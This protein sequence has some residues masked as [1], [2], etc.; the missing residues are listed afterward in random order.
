MNA[1]H[2]SLCLALAALLAAC[3]RARPR[4]HDAAV[5]PVDAERVP[6]IAEIPPPGPSADGAE[7]DVPLR[8]IH[9]L[10]EPAP[11]GSTPYAVVGATVPCGF[12]P[13]Y[14]VSERVEGE[15]HLRMRAQR[16]DGGAAG[17]VGGTPVVELV[18]LSQLRL[19]AWRVRDATAHG[20]QDP[21]SPEGPV[22][23][24]VPDDA[25]IAPPA[26]RWTRACDTGADC[27]GGGVCAR[28]GSGSICL[29]PMDPWL[30]LGR[31]C[32]EGTR[33]VEA[34]AVDRGGPAPWRA[35]V[36]ACT[37][38]QCPGRLRCDP[39]GICLPPSR[40]DAGTPA[41]SRGPSTQGQGAA[42]H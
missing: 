11:T 21:P 7:L 40:V 14:T 13:R 4:A 36:A 1:R 20:P 30:H 27:A 42:G 39:S 26:E 41:G 35:C 15:V 5:A 34:T 24:V 22:L 37:S 29:A 19:G 31:P 28:V 9:L 2:R 12:V 23:H 8:W 18:S 25:T 38:G 10:A 17:C 32:P 33:S 16:R 3:P 6:A